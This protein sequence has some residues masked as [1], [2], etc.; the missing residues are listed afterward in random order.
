M[1]AIR[2]VLLLIALCALPAHAHDEGAHASAG[3]PVP[4]Y[5]PGPGLS[6]SWYDPGRNGEGFVLEVLADG[7]FLM[8]WFTY[9][10][11]GEAGDQAWMIGISQQVEGNRVV[12]PEVYRALG[13]RWGDAFDPA[14]IRNE[15]WGALEMEFQDC[16]TLTVRYT[17][18]AGYGSGELQLV[19]LTELDELAC[20]GTRSLTASGGRALDGLRDHSGAWYVPSRSGEGW[21]V[22]ELPGDRTLAYWFTFDPQGRQAF[23]LGVGQRVGDEVELEGTLMTRG[24]RFGADFDPADVEHVPFGQMRIRFTSCNAMEVTYASSIAGYGSGTRSA[25]RL[26]QLASSHCIDATPQALGQVQWSEAAPMPAPAQSELDATVLDGRLYALGGYGDPRGFKRYDPTSNQWT[27]LAPLPAGRD[28]LSTFAIDGGVYYTGGEPNGGGVTGVSGFRY[29]V[30]SAQWEERPELPFNFGSRATV[31]NGQVYIG[32]ESG[33]LWQYDP[34][35]RTKRY[36]EGPL[37]AIAR[38]HAQVQAYLGE[39]WVMGGRYPETTSVAIFDP[40]TEQWRAGPRLRQFRAGFGATV[41]GHHLIAGGG[42]VIGG[43][44][45]LVPG[46]EAYAAGS[47]NWQVVS[48]LPVAVHGTAAVTLGNRAYFVSGST[49]AGRRCCATGRLFALEAG[50]P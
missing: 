23:I 8:N 24:A 30:A 29:D 46:V 27:V 21:Y 3:A 39:I 38:D 31:L 16:A 45:R 41:L 12:F 33:G 42:E 6:G 7:R 1:R 15:L 14:A 17:G 49:A 22:E 25:V 32:T 2:L 19:R 20:T 43:N 48:N 18:P 44:P 34:R 37:P 4:T 35:Q 11:T 9:P 5:W 10:A 13:G 28:H 40:V 50:T 47:E 36:L 26:S